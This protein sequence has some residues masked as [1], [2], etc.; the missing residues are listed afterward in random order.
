MDVA[1]GQG[2]ITPLNLNVQIQDGT[3]IINRQGS[4][5]DSNDIDTGKLVNVRGVLDVDNKTLLASL[6]VVDTDSSTK[7]VGTVGDNP[8]NSCGFTLMTASGDRSVATN[9]NTKVFMVTATDLNGSSNPINVSE[10]SA[11][12][13][14]DVYGNNANGCFEAHTIIAY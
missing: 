9:N 12:Q 10:L 14:T 1:P 7:L 11:G 6:I 13:Q 8:D 3:M 5:V 4:P 2:L